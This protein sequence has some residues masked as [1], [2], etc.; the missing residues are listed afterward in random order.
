[1]EYFINLRGQ[2][3]VAIIFRFIQLN[4]ML[5]TTLLE[6]LLNLFPFNSC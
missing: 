4:N 6:L 2:D 5:K 3:Y 1:M